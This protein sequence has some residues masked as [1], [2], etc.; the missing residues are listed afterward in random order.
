MYLRMNLTVHIDCISTRRRF[1]EHG[2]E[3]FRSPRIKGC[4]AIFAVGRSLWADRCR[5][6]NRYCMP[7]GN[8]WLPWG[9]L[10]ANRLE[11]P[12]PHRADSWKYW[13]RQPYI[14]LSAVSCARWSLSPLLATSFF[15]CPSSS[16]PWLFPIV[17][18]SAVSH[19]CPSVLSLLVPL[20]RLPAVNI[21]PSRFCNL[22]TTSKILG[23]CIY[24]DDE[25]GRTFVP[26][27]PLVSPRVSSFSFF[28][29]L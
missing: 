29:S 23:L 20:S 10:S 2:T 18:W 1:T 15:L 6:W 8:S 26:T 22:P 3:P 17:V 27:A 25:H 19:C 14:H 5:K 9:I 28:F 21:G 13:A 16:C 12:Q 7:A 4:P 24:H 11:L